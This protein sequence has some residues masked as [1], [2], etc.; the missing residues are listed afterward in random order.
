MKNKMSARG[1][2]NR[3]LAVALIAII[4]L[5]CVMTLTT[6]WKEIYNSAQRIGKVA[7][8]LPEDWDQFDM[9]NARF[10][11]L[12]D[13]LGTCLWKAEEL[14]YLNSAFQLAIG[15]KMLSTGGSQMVVLTTGHLHDVAEKKDAT[16]KAE[17]VA[18]WEQSLNGEVPFLFV[19]EHPVV[20]DESMFPE[21]YDLLDF[22][23]EYADELIA[24]TRAAGVKTIDSR[25]VLNES[26]YT[27]DD[28]LLKT[29]K[30][31]DTFA[32]LVMAKEI[33]QS[34][35]DITGTELDA[36]R[37]DPSQFETEVYEKLYLGNYG[38]RLGTGLIDPDDITVFWPSYDTN[39]TRSTIG[40][41]TEEITGPFKES[42]I[43]WKALERGEDGYN[44]TAYMDYGLTE[45][46]EYFQNSD[47]PAL[48]IALFKD[49]YSAPI[50]AFL[51]LVA[52]EVYAFDMRT[53]ID[54]YENLVEKY[55]PDVVVVAYSQYMLRKEAYK[56]VD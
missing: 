18:Q 47:A 36:N 30:H 35:S 41:T 49:S 11:S 21:G 3:V 46:V 6:N 52:N 7:P 1:I 32:A 13:C 42:V 54:T 28:L 34:I 14:G 24:G 48:R 53:P 12:E 50:G 8:Y 29:E 4:V 31:W 20:Y 5:G 17:E 45:S 19:Y 44:I 25:E 38:Q 37:L 23:K 40:K 16:S 33:T 56:F 15:K 9:L 43:R 2:V 10:R 22:S 27:L 26:G 55:D 51:S 39:I